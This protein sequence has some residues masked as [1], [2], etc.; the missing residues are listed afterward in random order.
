MSVAWK[1]VA[2]MITSASRLRPSWA[3]RMLP[4]TLARPTATSSAFGAVSAG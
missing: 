4:S 3:V 2:K 1:P